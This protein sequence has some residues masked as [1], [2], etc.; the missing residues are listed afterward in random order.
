MTWDVIADSP[1]TSQVVE[2]LQAELLPLLP[3]ASHETS[4]PGPRVKR[5]LL[6]NV[7]EGTSAD[8]RTRFE[9]DLI[10]MP[11]H[12]STIRSWALSRIDQSMA[13][14]SSRWT[15]AW[16][17]EFDDVEGLTGEYLLHPYHWTHVDRWFDPEAPESIVEPDLANLYRWAVGPVI[18][19]AGQARA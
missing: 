6:L 10:A 16:E 5:T 11:N 17:Q 18:G 3:L 8:V 14:A 15:H 1:P 19:K 13:G 7:R 9:A 4:T 12:I 2:Q